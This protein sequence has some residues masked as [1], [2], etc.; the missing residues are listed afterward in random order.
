MTIADVLSGAARWCVVEGDNAEVLPLLPD[1]SVAHVITDPP[2]SRHTHD[3]TR[4]AGLR[5]DGGKDLEAIGFDAIARADM[6]ALAQQASRIATRW[7][8]IFS[9]VEG[10]GGW[11]DAIEESGLQYIRTGAWVKIGMSPQ[12]SG[13]RPGTGFEA[14]VIAHPRGRKR[15]N[16]GGHV[17]IWNHW[18]AGRGVDARSHTTQKPVPLMLELVELFT[19]PDDIVLD[20]YC[21]SGTTG[22]ACLRLGRRFI[23]IEKD[24]VYAKV[25]HDRLVAE[26]NGQSLREARAG[27][28]PM[29]GEPPKQ[30][31][32]PKPE[33]MLRAGDGFGGT[34][35]P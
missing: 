9:D 17:A 20:P 27:Q 22:V 32:P 19:D 24:A 7:S 30:E 4:G 13:D 18:V 8:L 3:K 10:V 16:G 14:C 31:R 23:G 11:I 1:K 15:W 26:G 25:A 21:G 5:S 29:F 35:Y 34:D 6:G 33:D 2:Y 28:L 12:F